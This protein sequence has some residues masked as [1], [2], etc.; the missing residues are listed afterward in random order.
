MSY[1]VRNLM[2]KCNL[3]MHRSSENFK[4]FYETF[5]SKTYII[6][7]AKKMTR[8]NVQKQQTSRSI[9]TTEC[10]REIGCITATHRC[11]FIDDVASV[12]STTSPPSKAASCGSLRIHTDTGMTS[13]LLRFNSNCA[14]AKTC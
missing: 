2:V 14:C 7:Y 11:L 3:T 8:R 6:L 4:N 5:K 1:F 9:V 13:P 10:T 12:S